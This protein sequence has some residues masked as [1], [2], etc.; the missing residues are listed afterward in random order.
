MNIYDEL[1]HLTG[2][3]MARRSLAQ[4][5]MAQR[6]GVAPRTL[7]YFLCDKKV[8]REPTINRLVDLLRKDGLMLKTISTAGATAKARKGAKK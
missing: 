5:E 8:L 3:Y 2:V 7:T 4:W 6:I 1:R